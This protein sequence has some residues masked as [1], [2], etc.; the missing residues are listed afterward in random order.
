MGM[1][2]LCRVLKYDTYRHDKDRALL[3]VNGALVGVYRA[4][5]S[6]HRAF[7]SVYRVHMRI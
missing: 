1:A 4:L 6:I 7:M 3:S 2:A 5:F